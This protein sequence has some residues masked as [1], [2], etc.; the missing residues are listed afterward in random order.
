M[1]RNRLNILI[2]LI[3]LLCC[4]PVLVQAAALPVVSI[5]YAADAVLSCE[6]AVEA[7]ITLTLGG[8]ETDF[9]GKLRLNDKSLDM[10]EQLLPQQSLRIDSDG[11]S[12]ILYN[13]GVDAIF[14][15]VIPAVCRSLV[16]SGPL[17]VAVQAQEP[18]EVYLN[19]EYWGL[20]A[21]QET[22]EDAI[23]RF[24]G[25]ADASTL[26]VS[27][28]DDILKETMEQVAKLDLAK[29]EERAALEKLIDT[30]NMLNWLAVDVY[31]SKTLPMA[32]VYFY[33]VNN[34]PWKF[35]TAYFTYSLYTAQDNSAARLTDKSGMYAS[36]SGI[37][38]LVPRMMK[39]PVYRDAFLAKLGTLYQTWTTPV[40]QAVVDA[41]AARIAAALPAHMERWTEEFYAAVNDTLMYPAT[42][43][44]DGLLFQQYRLYRLR[45]KTLLCRPWYVYDSAQRELNVS[46]ED[47][48][49]L[50]GGPKPEL[51]EVPLDNFDMYKAARG[52]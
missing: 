20:Y 46:D 42:T 16:A 30:D 4:L 9:A 29:A 44:Q 1:K 38:Q 8:R 52:L 22:M 39:E 36:M 31:L 17:Q 26:R 40:M 49:R 41:E 43:P 33:Q 37:M 7:Q 24:E 11:A 18:V 21:K 27:N 10:T 34:G 25:L 23:V 45:D 48:A 35:S 15:K 13:D 3:L 12:F 2:P 47:M 51:P 50:F 5:D 19:G 32:E 14:T 6:T 28:G